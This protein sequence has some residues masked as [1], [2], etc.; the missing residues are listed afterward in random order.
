MLGLIQ[1]TLEQVV[2]EGFTSERI[3]AVLH[4]IEL[5]VKHQTSSFG[6]SMIMGV[7]P[8][9]NHGGNPIEA[10]Q[11]NAKVEQFRQQLSA[12]PDYLV[13]QIR[14]YLVDNQHRL[15]TVMSP[16]DQ[17]EAKLEAEEKEI[18]DGKCAALSSEQRQS[19]LSKGRQLLAMQS[20]VD[21]V[22]C[23][24]TLQISDIDAGVKR[25]HLEQLGVNGVPLQLSAQPTNGITYFR[26]AIN[27]SHLDDELKR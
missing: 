9:W 5:S 3:E 27:A 26:A 1:S 16:D 7:T 6:L 8:L 13:D 4:S 10:L 11:I 15:V 17:F 14:R 24:P 2:E 22:E 21:D 18:L 19:I 23:L 20:S 25:V 12:N